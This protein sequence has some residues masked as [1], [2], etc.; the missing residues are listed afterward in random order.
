MILIR[1]LSSRGEEGK[2]Q[3]DSGNLIVVTWSVREQDV[4]SPDSRKP[5]ERGARI[6]T[7]GIMGPRAESMRRID[8]EVGSVFLRTNARPLQQDTW[9]RRE[10]AAQQQRYHKEILAAP[11]FLCHNVIKN[12]ERP[13][14][15]GTGRIEQAPDMMESNDSTGCRLRAGVG[16]DRKETTAF[17]SVGVLK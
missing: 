4:R 5:H 11:G 14:N 2:L 8:K 17:Q 7:E 16:T 13:R 1:I 9:H 6:E 3:N 10:L 15:V 12:D